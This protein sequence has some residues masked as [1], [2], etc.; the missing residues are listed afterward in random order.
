MWLSP[1][2]PLNA[3]V[4]FSGQKHP[5]ERPS[6]WKEMFGGGMRE[7]K[8]GMMAFHN[9]QSGRACAAALFIPEVLGLGLQ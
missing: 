7:R 2:A 8:A 3:T 6:H 5:S 9:M 4:A 1:S